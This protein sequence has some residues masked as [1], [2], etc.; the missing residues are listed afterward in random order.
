MNRIIL[1]VGLGGFFGSIAR[2]LISVY[3]T[4][5]FPSAFPVGTFVVNLAGCFLI[6]LFYGLSLRNAWFTG[7]LL[8]FLTAGF[9]GGFTT[10]SSLAYENILLLRSAEYLAFGL[11]T[12]LSLAIGMAATYLGIIIT[13]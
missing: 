3:F 2:Y 6:G 7:D 13:R 9:C 12:L 4:K 5:N 11:Y 10:F 8:I 1:L